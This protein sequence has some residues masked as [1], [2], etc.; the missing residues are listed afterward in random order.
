MKPANLKIHILMTFIACHMLF[1]YGFM[2]V[3]LPPGNGIPLAELLLAVLILTVNHFTVLSRLGRLALLAPLGIWWGYGLTR[4][5]MGF[6]EHGI[7]AFRDAS[8]V[9]ESM[10]LILAFALTAN[11]ERMELVLK[12]IAV[13]LMVATAY[14]LM[15]PLADTL[16][17]M[18]P[19]LTGGSGQ[20]VSLLFSF[21][22]E[23]GGMILIWGA[24][25]L[26]L[27]RNHFRAPAAVIDILSGGILIF[28]IV[29]L[30]TRTVYL[31]ILGVLVLLFLTQRK[32]LYGAARW[33]PILAIAGAVPLLLG[34]QLE[35][36]FGERLSL[37]FFVNHFMSMFGSA[38][39]V[40]VE[41]A[42]EGVS[43]RLG[44]W[45]HILERL[46]SSP[47][48][49]L[50]GLGYGMPLVEFGYAPVGAEM[51]VDVREPH[52][53]YMSVVA[54]LGLVG[55][56]AW[57]WMHTQM[58]RVWWL[59]MQ[60]TKAMGWHVW[61]QR[62]ILCM[63]FFLMVWILALGEDGLEKPFI[64]IPYYFLWGIV[65]RFAYSLEI[66]GLLSATPA[67]SRIGNAAGSVLPLHGAVRQR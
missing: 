56:V 67:V 57:I 29:V 5:V 17:E 10:F 23:Q 42:A 32:S 20:T 13:T 41:A 35:T 14:R 50:F 43:M 7:W 63:A 9:I 37:D 22:R 55:F 39:D 49:L 12:W 6:L 31:Q 25:F 53:S 26:L 34:F 2:Q 61:R 62:L 65:L 58:I 47:G 60:A 64:I 40:A 45:A 21:T 4:A 48:T 30:H 11:Q 27:F 1:G 33:W 36:R 46:V 24:V 16:A 3:R 19:Q 59:S 8:Q 38:K 54:R 51:S 44:W 28:A 52:N 15:T 66:A 18:G